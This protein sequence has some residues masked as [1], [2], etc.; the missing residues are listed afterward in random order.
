[1][2]ATV[3]RNDAETPIDEEQELRIPVIGRER[4]AMRKHD[5]L[6]AAPVLVVDRDTIFGGNCIA[7][8]SYLPLALLGSMAA[9]WQ[10]PAAA[11]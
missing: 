6:T 2:A 7:H 3:V 8:G 11:D 5:R 10:G 4:P 1:M 9:V